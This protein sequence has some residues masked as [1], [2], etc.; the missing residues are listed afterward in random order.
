MEADKLTALT[1]TSC[2]NLTVIEQPHAPHNSRGEAAGTLS[3]VHLPVSNKL[4]SLG[5]SK[6]QIRLLFEVAGQ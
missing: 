1:D 2:P 5:T 6:H 4:R 3:I